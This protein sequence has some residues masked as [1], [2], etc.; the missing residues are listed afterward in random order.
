MTSTVRSPVPAAT[1][2]ASSSRVSLRLRFAQETSPPIDPIRD[3][4]VFDSSVALGDRSGLFQSSNRPVTILPER[5][6]SLSELPM[7]R[8]LT[9]DLTFDPAEGPN[10]IE[11][12]IA[13]IVDEAIYA[14]KDTSV[15]VLSDRSAGS[16][17]IASPSLRVV[18]RVHQALIRLGIRHRV[19]LVCDAGI[20]DIHHCALH[21]ALGADALC[22]WL[23][24]ALAGDREASY[25]KGL[26]SGFVEAMS[27]MGVTPSSAYCGASLVEAIGLDRKFVEAEFPGV[28]VH[29]GGIGVDVLD[30]E[31]F[32]FWESAYRQKEAEVD[33]MALA[34]GG[35]QTANL[36]PHSRSTS[37]GT[38]LPDAGEY[39]HSKDGRPHA[40]NA[41]IVRLLHSAS[42]YSKKIHRSEPGSYEAYKDYSE[43]V[44][45]RSPLSILDL[46]QLKGGVVIPLES[47]ESEAA[48]AWR[49]MAPGMSEGAL[50]EPAHRAVA[51]GLNVLNRWCRMQKVDLPASQGPFANS[52]EGGFDKDR[53]GTREGNPSVQY[54]GGR[55]TIT[56]MTAARAR[57][58]EVKFAQGAKP[59][60]G[61]QLPGK[62]V[63]AEVAKRR[64]CEPGFE[65]VSPPINHNLYSIEDVKLMVESWRHLNPRVN[66]A[67]K[68]VATHGV[69]MVTIGGVNAGANRLHISDGCGGT[70][71][72][73]RVD[74]KHA[75]VPVAAVLPTV[76]DMLVEEGVRHLVELSVDGG[77]QNGEQALKLFL[78]GADRVGFGT[79]LLIAIGCSMLRKCHLAGP[80][81]ADPTGKRRL[82]C[83]PGVATQD[84]A[85]IA[86]FTGRSKHIARYLIYVAREVRELMA[87]N[88]IQNLG[89]AIGRRDLLTKKPDLGGKA[90]LIDLATVLSAPHARVSHRDYRAQ[91][92]NHLPK[93]REQERCVAQRAIAGDHSILRE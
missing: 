44:Y 56:P 22:P 52:G 12:T 24:C 41:E 63:S 76:Q 93:L 78:L 27:M 85:H 21:V 9:L 91:T 43:L 17:R 40:N 11:N 75:G 74:Q 49:F 80:D 3:S 65:L 13:R 59:G 1:A 79:S 60:K 83:T 67:L 39:R 48:I 77:V 73:K 61:G 2:G 25:L 18:S 92:A 57:E 30:Q 53:I 7:A 54:A 32:A 28:P 69:E 15:I 89:E 58:A 14:A 19:G 64:G 42:G 72:A 88:D 23:G 90:A 6:L 20:W 33:Q 29:L 5:L 31:W 81:P 35:S 4:W 10:G 62:K 38:A 46:I 16:D 86:K 66:C 55:F 68:Y 34:R 26:R 71:A 82:G 37:G 47:V 51:R 84:P 45:G 8:S 87:Q 36:Q 50:S 70:G